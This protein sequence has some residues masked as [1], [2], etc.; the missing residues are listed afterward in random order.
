MNSWTESL[1]LFEIYLDI[2]GKGELEAHKWLSFSTLWA[3][4]F[5]RE[6]VGVRCFQYRTL[7]LVCFYFMCPWIPTEQTWCERFW[8][9]LNTAGENK[10]SMTQDQMHVLLQRLLWERFYFPPSFTISRKASNSS[11]TQNL[12]W[13]KIVQH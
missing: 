8:W 11:Y 10:R 4:T 13:P 12:H 5:L 7:G 2:E 3:K 6:K 1:A 9:N